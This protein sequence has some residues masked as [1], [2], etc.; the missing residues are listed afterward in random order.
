MKQAIQEGFI[1]DVLANYTPVGSY[2]KLMKTV[3]DE[4]L[5]YPAPALDGWADRARQWSERGEAFVFLISGAKVRN[6]ASAQAL[7]ERLGR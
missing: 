7:I 4:P 6:P 2:Y 3:E 5:G 1:V